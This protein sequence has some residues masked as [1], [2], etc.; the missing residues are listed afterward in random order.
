M[1][2]T[3]LRVVVRHG[4]GDAGVFG[5]AD[6]YY[7]TVESQGRLTLHLHLLI[8][9]KGSISPAEIRRRIRDNGQ[10]FAYH[11]TSWLDSVHQSHFN[12]GSLD[13]VRGRVCQNRE[14]EGEGRDDFSYPTSMSEMEATLADNAEL[15]NATLHLPQP[16]GAINEEQARHWYTSVCTDADE[17]VYR[18]NVHT[19]NQNPRYDSCRRGRM[20][21]CRARFPRTKV[22]A[23]VVDFDT[24]CITLRQGEE[25]INHYSVLTTYLLRCNTDVTCLLSGTQAKAVVAYVTDYLTKSPLKVYSI[26]ECIKTVLGRNE[27]MFNE[28]SSRE[29]A[30]RRLL[31]K[32][33]NTL[34]TKMEIGGPMLALH[35]CGGKDHFTPNVFRVF[36]WYSYVQVVEDSW[37]DDEGWRAEVGERTDD[38]SFDAQILLAPEHPGEWLTLRR[39]AAGDVTGFSHLS[40]YT[41]RPIELEEM[42]LYDF[43]RTT[44]VKKV[45]SDVRQSVAVARN[46]GGNGSPQFSAGDSEVHDVEDDEM[47]GEDDID[48]SRAFSFADGHPRRATHAVFMLRPD[49]HFV[50]NFIGKTLPR[51][52]RGDREEYCR[53]M[54]AIFAPRGWRSGRDLKADNETWSAKFEDTVFSETSLTVMKNMHLLYECHDARHDFAAQRK[55]EERRAELAG[56]LGD[57]IMDELDLDHEMEVCSED[58][59]DRSLVDYLELSSELVGQYTATQRHKMR[60]IL[61]YMEEIGWTRSLGVI[62]METNVL[63]PQEVFATGLTASAWKESLDRNREDVLRARAALRHVSRDGLAAIGPPELEEGL[64]K[65]MTLSQLTANAV[66]QHLPHHLSSTVGQ[67]SDGMSSII[68]EFQLNKEQRRAFLLVALQMSGVHNDPLRMYLGGMGGTGK[69]QV[70]KAVISYLERRKEAY[71]YEVCAPTGAAASIIAGSTYHSVLGFGRDDRAASVA[72]LSKVRSRLEGVDLIILDEVSMMS[73]SAVYRVSEQLCNAFDDMLN[74]FGG[75]SIVFA[76]DFGQLPPPGIGQLPLYSSNI[77]DLSTMATLNGQKNALGKIAWHMFTTHVILRQNMRQTTVS[78]QDDAYRRLLVNARHRMC[79]SRDVALLD[80]VTVGRGHGGDV[81]PAF[82]NASIITAWNAHRDAINDASV[83]RFGAD[84]HSGLTHFYSRDKL[85]VPRDSQSIRR[86]QKLSDETVAA[87]TK[88]CEIPRSLQQTLWDLPPSMTDHVPGRLSL[89]LGMP[90]MLKFN[91]ATE[92]CATNGA[93]GTVYGWDDVIGS[94]GRRHLQTLFVQ[95]TSPPRSIQIDGL[96][97]NVIPVPSCTDKIRCTLPNDSAVWI[98]REQVMVLPNFAMTDF[99]V[100]GRTRI[101]NPMDLRHCKTHQSVYTCLSRSATFEGT[102]VL[103]PFDVRKIQGG[104]STDLLR[105]FRELEI[106]DDI[107]ERRFDGTLPS[108]VRGSTRSELI[109]SYQSTYGKLYV[110]HEV[111][112]AVDWSAADPRKLEP[113]GSMEMWRS[114]YRRKCH[115]RR[116]P[117][118]TRDGTQGSKHRKQDDGKLPCTVQRDC[119]RNLH[120]PVYSEVPSGPRWDAN[121]WSCVY[122]AFLTIVYNAEKDEALLT[123]LSNGGVNISGTVLHGVKNLPGGQSDLCALRTSWREELYQRDS[124]KF[125]KGRRLTAMDAVFDALFMPKTEVSDTNMRCVVCGRR[126]SPWRLWSYLHLAYPHLWTSDELPSRC[127]AREL[128]EKIV[129]VRRRNLFCECEDDVSSGIIGG[130]NATNLS[131]VGIEIPVGT[132][133]F[134]EVSADKEFEMVVDR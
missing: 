115:K 21:K 72:K 42:S 84:V 39:T 91:Y 53:T 45:D 92:L 109:K 46:S 59:V 2:E 14:L 7:G 78:S 18:C 1:V 108:T 54:M 131:L 133:V 97:L 101:F 70:I 61:A 129:N 38:D 67:I 128:F 74:P 75:K 81:D 34:T 13:D 32:M 80:S 62:G 47:S 8:W 6:T 22:P 104:L 10:D 124:A 28:C 134:P 43:M 15:R 60:E 113:C 88:S 132:I 48:Y 5:E 29:E 114:A 33:V 127:S 63:L 30:S 44:R 79:D 83:T 19:H 87:P 3:F 102:L 65:I 76:G 112:P 69:S 41:H 31:T 116:A 71:R 99:A 86:S 68:V 89:C 24:G 11:L 51:P 58:N 12:T 50:L 107:T 52:D 35:M 57:D 49:K 119:G 9:L 4:R 40:D 123:R 66:V 90:V 122:D 82:Q 106:M 16:S 37:T 23:T 26:L 110:P 126:S 105:E 118:D 27:A 125:P 25:W 36:A 120:S 77:G 94:D 55:A 96:P 111:H 20:R 73:C 100:Q 130:R 117:A 93:E 103:A 98:N 17:L 121:D 95:L 56:I 64:V 85:A